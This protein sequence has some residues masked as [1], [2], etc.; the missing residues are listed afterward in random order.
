MEVSP[1][2]IAN[3]AFQNYTDRDH[4]R[5]AI[6]SRYEVGTDQY[7][8]AFHKRG[9][10][11]YFVTGQ[12]SGTEGFCFILQAQK[13]TFGSYYSTYYRWAALL[14]N[15]TLNRLY[16]IDGSPV[17][18]ATAVNITENKNNSAVND[19]T[20]D[21]VEATPIRSINQFVTGN[22]TFSIEVYHQIATNI[23]E[24]REN[25]TSTALP[26]SLHIFHSW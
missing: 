6:T 23:E 5:V 11:S 15:A 3:V 22:R 14:G 21:F 8:Q 1:Y 16:I 24:I 4:Y 26:N 12:R 7:I 2:I 10:S 18:T 17:V 20:H 19:T 9:M 25:F 13:E